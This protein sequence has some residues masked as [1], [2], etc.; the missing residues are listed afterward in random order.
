M[1][2]YRA[3]HP[4]P[5][6]RLLAFFQFAHLP[7]RLQH[8]SLPFCALA[9]ELEH[10]LP[11]GSEKTVALRKLLEAKDCAVRS[12]IESPDWSVPEHGGARWRPARPGA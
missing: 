12:V 3:Q 11:A 9:V 10:L 1:S 7:P 4:S 8:I 5:S 2:E 6:E